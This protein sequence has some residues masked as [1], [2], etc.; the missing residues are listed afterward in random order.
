MG[1]Q[2]NWMVPVWVSLVVLAMWI[3]AGMGIVALFRWARARRR[4]PR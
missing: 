1:A 2:V 4:R 3:A